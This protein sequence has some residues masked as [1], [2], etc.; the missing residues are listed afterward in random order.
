MVQYVSKF[1]ILEPGSIQMGRQKRISMNRIPNEKSRDSWFFKTQTRAYLESLSNW[2]T[3]KVWSSNSYW[4]PIGSNSTHS[5]TLIWDN[6]YDAERVRYTWIPTYCYSTIIWQIKGKPVK[7]GKYFFEKLT[8]WLLLSVNQLPSPFAQS[9]IFTR[10]PTLL[11]QKV[12][13]LGE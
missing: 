8:P 1:L 6:F 2:P 5:L 7:K 11:S 9:S 13:L 10:I 4:R 12:P 3:M